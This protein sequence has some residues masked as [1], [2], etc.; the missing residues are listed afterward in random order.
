VKPSAKLLVE[1]E[2]TQ[3][4]YRFAHH[5]DTGNFDA[6]IS[7]FV[8]DGVFDRVGQ[9]LTG[10]EQMRVAYRDRPKGLTT[11][12]IVTNVCFLHAQPDRAEAFVYNLTYH[13]SG[14]A[15]GQPLVYAS[16]NGRFI[17]F[18][19]HYELTADGWRFSSREARPIFLSQD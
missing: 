5:V 11:R 17:D 13:A 3:L 4:C 14:D 8:P 19:D 7:L 16:Q 6:M 18:H 12:H 15:S 9:R 10:H 2:C 1:W